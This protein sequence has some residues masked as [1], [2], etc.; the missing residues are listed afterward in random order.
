[1]SKSILIVDDD[2][3]VCS[4]LAMVFREEGYL[5]YEVTSSVEAILTIKKDKYDVYLFDYKM[6]GSNG[7]DLLKIVKALNPQSPVFIISGMLNINEL[8]AKEIKSGLIAGVISKPFDVNILLQK[9][10]ASIE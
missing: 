7:I 2:L 4:A 8:C 1:M 5:V 9:V 10:A 3:G 6:K